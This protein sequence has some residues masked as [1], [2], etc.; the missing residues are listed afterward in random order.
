MNLRTTNPLPNKVSSRPNLYFKVCCLA[1]V[2]GAALQPFARA[3]KSEIGAGFGVG[4]NGDDR[5]FLSAMGHAAW[6]ESFFGR[7]YVHGERNGIESHHSILGDLSYRTPLPF[8]LTKRFTA[9]LGLGFL[10]DTTR[11]AGTNTSAPKQGTSYNCGLVLG[12]TFR[13]LSW[14]DT[15]VSADWQAHVFPA[16]WATVYLSTGKRQFLSLLV[17]AEL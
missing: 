17:G 6:N 9:N 14:G 12:V 1:F 16:G 8:Q 13:I 2:T 3:D 15:F 5:F 7:I 4:E 11:I 10:A